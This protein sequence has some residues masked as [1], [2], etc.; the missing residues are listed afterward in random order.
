MMGVEFVCL[1]GGLAGAMMD[2]FYFGI[3]LGV[4]AMMA[5]IS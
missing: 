1:L 5:V 4:M 3:F 2:W